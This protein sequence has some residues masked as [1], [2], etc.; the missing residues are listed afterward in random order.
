MNALYIG[1]RLFGIGK[2]SFSFLGPKIW[3]G[4]PFE[5]KLKLINIFKSKLKKHYVEKY[6]LE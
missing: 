5:I 6:L 1:R 4:I 3:A 2:K